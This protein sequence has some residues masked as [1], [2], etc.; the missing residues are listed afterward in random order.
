MAQENYDLERQSVTALANI[1]NRAFYHSKIERLFENGIGS[2]AFQ[3]DE[4]IGF[5]AFSQIIDTG[6]GNGVLGR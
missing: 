5:L 1:D 6:N 2:I 3:N 4:P